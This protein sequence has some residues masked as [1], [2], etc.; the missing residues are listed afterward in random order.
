MVVDV[1]SRNIEASAKRDCEMGEIAAYA[2][3]LL[4]GFERGSGRPRPRI[5]KLDV[6]M[7]EIVHRLHAPPSGE[8]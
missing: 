8:G 5:V 3:P 2:D 6:L 1:P 7:D 4:E